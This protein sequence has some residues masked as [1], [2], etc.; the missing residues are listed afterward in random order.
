MSNHKTLLTQVE[1]LLTER[2]Q[3]AARCKEYQDQLRDFDR[4]RGE[5]NIYQNEAIELRDE[6]A[7]LQGEAKA[8]A[9]E[10]EWRDADE[11]DIG[12]D[13]YVEQSISGL[14]KQTEPRKLIAI[15]NNR[16]FKYFCE[17]IGDNEYLCPW[18]QARVRTSGKGA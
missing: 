9:G 10:G 4:M 18:K 1:E 5:R 16:E 6:L 2:D 14:G 13:V 3:L 17:D 7:K 11:R 15:R 12:K 8:E